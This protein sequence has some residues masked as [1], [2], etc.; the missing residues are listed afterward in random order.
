MD[1]R[2]YRQM[3]HLRKVGAVVWEGRF[4]FIHVMYTTDDESLSVQIRPERED[5]RL[6]REQLHI[7]YNRDKTEI[8]RISY[9]FDMCVDY[10]TC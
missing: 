2:M 3:I 1:C 5:V 8:E 9:S 6:P 7:T 10:T 4:H